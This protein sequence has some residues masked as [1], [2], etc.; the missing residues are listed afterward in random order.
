MKSGT[1]RDRPFLGGEMLKKCGAL[2]SP[3]HLKTELII[4]ILYIYICLYVSHTVL[5]RLAKKVVFF[6]FETRGVVLFG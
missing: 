3:I 5:K 1:L 6:L 4:F 2:E